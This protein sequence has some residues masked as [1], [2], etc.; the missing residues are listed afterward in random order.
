MRKVRRP[1]G[2]NLESSKQVTF[3][4]QLGFYR[5]LLD[6]ILKTGAVSLPIP[7][8]LIYNYLRFIGHKDLF[9]A[10]VLSLAGLSAL[11]QAF[12]LIWV[13]VTASIVAPS[14]IIVGLL[15]RNSGR[16]PTKAL[17]NF[18]LLSSLIW[19]LCYAGAAYLAG[20]ATYPSWI[21]WTGAGVVVVT[22]WIILTT[23][24]WWSPGWLPIIPD[25]EIDW[26]L[27]LTKPKRK[28]VRF[29]QSISTHRVGMCIRLTTP[30]VFA[31]VYAVTAISVISLFAG[32]WHLPQ[33]GFKASMVFFLIIFASFLPGAI[34]LRVRAYNKSPGKALKIALIATVAMTYI[35]LLNGVSAQPIALA[36]MRA[37]A[38]I[39]NTPRTYEI[40]KPDERQIYSALGY[41]AMTG[42]RFVQAFIHFQ[43]ADIRFVCPRPV[44]FNERQA[45]PGNDHRSNNDSAPSAVSDDA[46][47]RADAAGCL[48]PTKDEIRVVD[49]PSSFKLPPDP[50]ATPIASERPKLRVKSGTPTGH[51]ARRPTSACIAGR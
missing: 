16:A 50:P 25:N 30:I 35:A 9:G 34:Y 33:R 1:G 28:V 22:I 4:D 10:S 42:D 2:E 24:A 36:A 46:A 19:S 11:L 29:V 5:D 44:D 15:D 7:A 17:P 48:V 3:R 40:L 13:A 18:I 38:I 23:M 6:A 20:D 49:L 26:S 39:D 43:F 37:M 41:K 45:I 51:R 8:I 21:Y 31:G 47:P 14:G 27:R 32:S 12:L